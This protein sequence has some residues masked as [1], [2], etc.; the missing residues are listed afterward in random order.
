MKNN[1]NRNLEIVSRIDDDI[2]ERNTKKRINFLSRLRK[3]KIR[4]WVISGVSMAA[5]LALILTAALV[6]IPLLGKQVPVYTGMTASS[7]PGAV[8]VSVDAGLNFLSSG[9]NASGDY[10]GGRGEPDQND[11]FGKGS[12]KD[13]IK[14]SLKIT[15][16]SEAIYYTKPNTDFYITVHFENPDNFLIQG[17]TIN[18]VTYADYMFEKGSDMEHVTVKMNA[19]NTEGLIDYTIDDITYIDR[20]KVKYVEIGGDRTVKI[21]VS[22]D[23]QPTAV[24]SNE[25]LGYNSVQFKVNTTDALG[26]VGISNGSLQAVLYNGDT[27]VATKDISGVGERTVTFENLA[28]NTLYQYAIVATYDALDGKGQSAYV[29]ASKAF[30]TRSPLL[31]SS[32]NVGK[33]DISFSYTYETGIPNNLLQSAALYQNGTKLRDLALTETSITGLT[34]N[35]TYR[36][37]ATYLWEGKSESIV[38]DF[39][40]ASLVVTVEHYLE[41]TDGTYGEPYL[42]ERVPVDAGV[43]TPMPTKTYENFITPQVQNAVAVVGNEPTVR[44]YY[45]RSGVTLLLVGNNGEAATPLSLKVGAQLPDAVR[46]GYTFEGWYLDVGQ[47]V[48]VDAAPAEG[49]TLY[50]KWAEESAAALF[51]FSVGTISGV[52]DRT[53]TELHIPTY[54]GGELV[55][56]IGFAAFGNLTTLE[57]VSLPESVLEIGSSAFAGCGALTS[58][59]V[60]ASNLYWKNEAGSFVVLND[61]SE[62]VTLLTET[63]VA[64]KLILTD[65]IFGFTLNSAGTGYILESIAPPQRFGLTIY[66]HLVL[67]AYYNGLPVVQI[68]DASHAAEFG[69]GGKFATGFTIPATVTKVSPSVFRYSTDMSSIVLAEGNTVYTMVD[70]CLVEK[71]T[72]MI[73][74]APKGAAL[75]TDASVTGILSYAFAGRFTGSS[76]VIPDHYTTVYTMAF[77]DCTLITGI[78]IPATLTTDATV[79]NIFN[80]CTD[81]TTIT[82]T[83]GNGGTALWRAEG[84]CL[85]EIATNTLVMVGK[86]VTAIPAG[87]AAI[88]SSAFSGNTA[89]TS[90]SIPATV[91]TIDEYAFRGCTALESIT[92]PVSVTMIGMGAFNGCSSLGS[93]VFENAAESGGEDLTLGPDLFFGCTALESLVIPARAKILNVPFRNMPALKT[94]R[95]YGSFSFNINN[96]EILVTRFFSHC[97]ELVTIEVTYQNGSLL[98]NILRGHEQK[99][100]PA[101]NPQLVFFD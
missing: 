85:T 70:G 95:F 28:I 84:N 26:L 24:T 44:Y 77:A 59:T 38:I 13:V 8:T 93:F 16:T 42:V 34:P 19:G 18:G 17:F 14:D 63:H 68:G 4:R 86:N 94:I 88:G 31:F 87:I 1:Q 100:Y 67:P 82:V 89:L 61:A 47:T 69:M 74:L 35:T 92:I 64:S 25:M 90:I 15:G 72:G 3:A 20:G 76:V 80:G 53:V 29:L 58:V 71:A 33:S 32:V 39:T 40:T 52:N 57:S 46:G 73:V 60:P 62:N 37:L 36:L 7:T 97:D 54:I 21:G 91:K 66:D 98:E 65:G 78:S 41:S 23:K 12:I 48:R 10:S 83:A 79:T 22:T 51:S 56:K 99:S 45:M 96:W 6:L 5:S 55:T 9:A 2:V 49:G 27:I 11:P 50:A 30:Y 75:P 101:K 81:I 43:S